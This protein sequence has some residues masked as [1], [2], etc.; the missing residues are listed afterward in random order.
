MFGSSPKNNQLERS[1]VCSFVCLCW[2]VVAW[3]TNR[4]NLLQRR[5]RVG[6]VPGVSAPAID[7]SNFSYLGLLGECSLV[8][9]RR[10]QGVALHVCVTLFAMPLLSVTGSFYPF[11]T[12][13]QFR[14]GSV[15]V[16]IIFTTNTH[17]R[18]GRMRFAF[19]TTRRCSRTHVRTF[20]PQIFPQ[21]VF[22]LLLTPFLPGGGVVF[23]TVLLPQ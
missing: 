22:V 23:R 20:L 4:L 14:A 6:C 15:Q 17:F 1:V 2:I 21:F 19:H 10:A 16:S 5:A 7:R 3:K 13:A 12:F 9:V 11:H 8:W 18:G